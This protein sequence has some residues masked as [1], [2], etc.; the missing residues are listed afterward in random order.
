ML[1]YGRKQKIWILG[2]GLVGLAL[3]VLWISPL[4]TFWKF[5]NR[6]R[7]ISTG[8]SVPGELRELQGHGGT[9][10]A[11]AG[12]ARAV[13]EHPSTPSKEPKTTNSAELQLDTPLTSSRKDASEGSVPATVSVDNFWD[14]LL[15]DLEEVRLR[16][17]EDSQP[18]DPRGPRR[19]STISLG[20]MPGPLEDTLEYSPRCR[21]QIRSLG[22]A[23]IGPLG[24][25]Y[26]NGLPEEDLAMWVVIFLGETVYWANYSRVE[27]SFWQYQD[28]GALPALEEALRDPREKV[29][30]AAVRSLGCLGRKGLETIATN[31]MLWAQADESFALY[32][33][34][35]FDGFI[36]SIE[37][38]E[39]EALQLPIVIDALSALLYDPRPKVRAAAEGALHQSTLG[40]QALSNLRPWNR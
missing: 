22:S 13:L 36:V 5:P 11:R 10:T 6:E 28:H 33:L 23:V 35:Y 21:S 7:N 3:T 14:V 38:K 1:R 30:I 18:W 15:H 31:M 2:V 17:G 27:R 19:I 16:K 37:D 29:R 25:K 26:L 24:Q 40:R 20:G 39:P 32:C 8:T 4:G 12:S 34:K 9:P